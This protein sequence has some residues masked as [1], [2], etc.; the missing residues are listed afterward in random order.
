MGIARAL[1]N[2]PQ[3]LILDEATSA[4]DN[5]TEKAVIDAINNLNKDIT[6]IFVAHRLNTIKNCDIV[7]KLEKGRIV[8]QEKIND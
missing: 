1:Y 4:L 2:N 6:I 3:L 8:N 7:L 5:D